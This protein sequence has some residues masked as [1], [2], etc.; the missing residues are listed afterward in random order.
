MEA[1]WRHQ[2]CVLKQN[3]QKFQI[4]LFLLTRS[5]SPH[6][7]STFIKKSFQALDF[8][9]NDNFHIFITQKIIY[10]FPSFNKQRVGLSLTPFAQLLPSRKFSGKERPEDT[11]KLQISTATKE[12]AGH[13]FTSFSSA[14]LGLQCV[15]LV[16][17]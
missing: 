14:F 2:E 12:S 3:R 5:C 8:I 17:E 13:S 6:K 15:M 10:T 7:H 1:S 9:Y 11:G 4:L 16:L